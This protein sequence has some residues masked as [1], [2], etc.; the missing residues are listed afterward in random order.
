[1]ADEKL[2]KLYYKTYLSVIEGSLGTRMFQHFFVQKLD[3]SEELDV[4]NEGEYSGAFYVSAIL[5]LIGYIK[6]PHSTVDSTLKD[7]E[8]SDWMKTETPK[9]GDIIVFDKHPVFGT[10]NLGFYWDGQTAI[11]NYYEDRVPVKKD[12]EDNRT[13]LSYW[14]RDYEKTI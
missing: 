5:A 10:E 13:V 3:S 12:L 9:Q 7:M 11:Y 1:M 2:K 6:R 8:E 4:M 14:T